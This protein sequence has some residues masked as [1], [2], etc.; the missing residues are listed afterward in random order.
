MNKQGL[1]NW[2][3]RTIYNFDQFTVEKR[4]KKNLFANLLE[5]EELKRQVSIL[6]LI[7]LKWFHQTHP[8][9]I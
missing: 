9:S 4:K 7:P 3:A 1:S 8:F 2:L 5:L 6:L